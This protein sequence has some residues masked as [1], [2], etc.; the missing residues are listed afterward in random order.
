MTGTALT[1]EDEFREIYKLDVVEVPTNKPMI[2]DDHNDVLYKTIAGKYKAIVEQVKKC[3][4]KGQPVLVGT[5]SID[6]SEILSKLLDREGIKHTVLNAKLHEKEA[7]IV[8]QAG[9]YGAVTISTNM[10]GRGTD[11]MLGGNSEFM[12][13]KEMQKQG[14]SDELIALSTGSAVVDDKE[15]MN[16]RKTFAELN[17]KFKAEIEPEA[18]KVREAGGLFILGS[19]RHES[20]RI[21]NQLR[22]RAGRQ[23]DPGESCFFLSLEDDL[24]RLFGGDRMYAMAN[25]LG[26]GDEDCLD[27]KMFSGV[28]ESSQKKIEDMNFKRR[29]NVLAYDDV[30]NQ[31][32]E[33][34]Y[35]QRRDVLNGENISEKIKNMIETSIAAEAQN[36]WNEDEKSIDAT[37]L[38]AYFEGLL[39]DKY[40]SDAIEEA[41]SGGDIDKASDALC[42]AALEIYAEKEE[43]F[44]QDTFREVERAVL[45]R[46]VDRKW[47]DHIDAMDDLKG[48]IGLQSFAQR[49]PVNEYRIRASE[50]FDELVSDIRE[51]TVRMILS[52]TPKAPDTKRVQIANP[53][54]ASASGEVAKKKITVVKGEKVGRNDP[55]PCGSGKKYKSCC[56][57]NR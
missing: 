43:L 12:A 25:S 42:A 30:M 39:R 9:K 23:G 10:A 8:A 27:F 31:Q 14:F 5:V 1:E 6:K 24:L 40:P 7:E 17:R 50:M 28:I 11:I 35:K 2:R 33:L 13:K 57:A 21:D 45:L 48:S 37:A 20:R 15:I 3:H 49:D 54:M 47:M 56:G 4:E 32:R 46:N 53:I 16:A 26:M 51:N 19:E 34:I 41:L 18:E 36:Y 55:C 52:V 29:K 44:G 22:G 38:K